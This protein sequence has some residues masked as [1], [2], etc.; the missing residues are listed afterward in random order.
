MMLSALDLPG[1]RKKHNNTEED[2]NMMAGMLKK[3]P[4][5]AI[6][7]IGQEPI[8]CFCCMRQLDVQIPLHTLDMMLVC[9]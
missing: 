8:S 3:K 6:R 2:A 9:L 4:C 5:R 7:P 1:S